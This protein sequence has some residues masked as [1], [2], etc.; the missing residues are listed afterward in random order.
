MPWIARLVSS[1]EITVAFY[2]AYIVDTIG[3][4]AIQASEPWAARGHAHNPIQVTVWRRY[5]RWPFEMETPGAVLKLV[6]KSLY[7]IKVIP[8]VVHLKTGSLKAVLAIVRG[9]IS[10]DLEA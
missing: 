2:E 6:H 9:Q 7:E 4:G 1:R 8:S 10:I 5:A 3:S